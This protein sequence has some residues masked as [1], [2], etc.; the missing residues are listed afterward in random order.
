MVT[1]SSKDIK[2]RRL[3]DRDD[4]T[5]EERQK[6]I[7]K[8]ISVLRRREVE[9]YLYDDNVLSTFLKNIDKKQCTDCILKERKILLSKPQT[10]DDN[11]KDISQELL[12]YIRDS[13]K[14]I[15]LGNTCREF[16]EQHLI[17]AL[18]QTPNVLQE[19]TSDI[20]P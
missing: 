19:L 1:L 2:V 17:E 9:N 12:I 16:A 11:L 18:K 3:I 5:D 10:G 7:N 15:S 13:T 14:H 4:M 6:K 8:G 20:F